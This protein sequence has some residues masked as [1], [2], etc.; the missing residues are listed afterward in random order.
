[1]AR[2]KAQEHLT[3]EMRERFI[4]AV[5]EI[6]PLALPTVRDALSLLESKLDLGGAILVA[7]DLLQTIDAVAAVAG[8]TLFDLIARYAQSAV[9]SLALLGTRVLPFVGSTDALRPLFIA[10]LHHDYDEIVLTALAHLRRS[11]GGGL[12]E[13]VIEHLQPTLIKSS[14]GI[15]LRA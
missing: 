9:P 5:R 12:D 8:P 6:G 3:F 4:S 15:A 14:R 11:A 2:V 7:E 10:Q 1:S 13:E